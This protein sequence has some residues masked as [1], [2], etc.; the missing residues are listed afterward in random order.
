MREKGPV[1]FRIGLGFAVLGLVVVNTHAWWR[2]WTGGLV[3]DAFRFVVPV[4]T[5]VGLI[6]AATYGALLAYPAARSWGVAVGDA[7]LTGSGLVSLAVFLNTYPLDLGAIGLADLDG[8]VQFA[9]GVALFALLVVLVIQLV[10]A[11]GAVVSSSAT[12]RGPTPAAGGGSRTVPLR[13]PPA[14]RRHRS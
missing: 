9:L 2:P 7:V 14:S 8:L 11:G 3:T 6:H 4:A 10:R 12:P 5:V 13:P 1:D